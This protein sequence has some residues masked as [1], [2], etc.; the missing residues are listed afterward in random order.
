MTHKIMTGIGPIRVLTLLTLTICVSSLSGC[1]GPGSKAVQTH[2]QAM[3]SITENE[4]V[5]PKKPVDRHYIG[6]AW[7]KQFGPIE[8]SST[9][10]IRVKKEKSFNS[11]QQDFAYKAGFGLGGQVIIGPQAHAGIEGSSL[12][13]TKLEGIEIVTPLSLADIPFEPNVPYVTEALRIANFTLKGETSSKA[14]VNVSSNILVGSG[15]ALAEAGG[16][17][18]TGTEGEGLV[19]AYK[20]HTIDLKTYVKEDSG[21]VPLELDTYLDFPKTNLLIK[22]KLQTIEAGAKKSLPRNLLWSCERADAM[23]RDMVAAWLV[24]VK[25]TDPKRKS[26]TVAFPAFPRIEDCNNYNGIIYSRIDPVTDKIHRQKINISIIEAE[27]SDVLKPV[28]WVARISLI[29]ESFKIRLLK[30]SDLAGK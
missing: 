3:E 29:N 17:S 1:A 11:M 25:S 4:Y 26:L 6:S 27:I 30:P 21:A 15:T 19:V 20:L 28:K 5:I 9:A 2:Q 12:D 24:E 18:R 22:A 10:D 23:S 7:S 14:G 13:K 8:D 16:K